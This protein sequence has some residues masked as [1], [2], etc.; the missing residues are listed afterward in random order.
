MPRKH[1][2]LRA[3]AGELASSTLTAWVVTERW[4]SALLRLLSPKAAD[5]CG[6]LIKPL[7]VPTALIRRK[8]IS[9][10]DQLA[11]RQTYPIEKN[12]SVNR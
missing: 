5:T 12:C 11:A 10:L 7:F 6:L 3:S 8:A 9:G 4:G 1:S 2:R